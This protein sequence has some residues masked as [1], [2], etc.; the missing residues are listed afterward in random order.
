MAPSYR[1]VLKALLFASVIAVFVP[2]LRLGLCASDDYCYVR[3]CDFVTAGLTFHGLFRAF[4][5]LSQ[6]IWM[7]LTWL[8]YML[9]YSIGWGEWGM[10]L[11]NVLLHAVNALLLFA[12]LRRVACTLGKGLFAELVAFVAAV[13]WAVHPLRVESVV[14][15]AS[16]KDELSTLFLLLA[17]LVWIGGSETRRTLF[18]LSLV[19]VGAMAKPSVMVFP[20][21][22]L[23]LDWLVVGNVKRREAYVAAIALTAVIAWE[24]SVGQGVEAMEYGRQIPLGYRLLNSVAALT[25]YIGNFLWPDPLAVQCMIRYPDRPAF[26]AVGSF[27]LT[28]MLL[29]ILVLAVRRVLEMSRTRDWKM[30]CAG[31]QRMNT[32]LAGCLV[33]LGSFVPFLGIVGFGFH[34]F[35]DR[36]TLLPSMGLSILILSL[37]VRGGCRWLRGI[38]F[39]I[40]VATIPFLV[41]RTVDQVGYWKDD[42]TLFEHTIAVDGDRNVAAHRTCGIYY[43]EVKHDMEKVYVHLKKAY[44][45][46]PNDYIRDQMGSCLHFLVEAMYETGR[47][48]EAED[49]YFEMRKW[50]YRQ[51]RGLRHSMEF[52]SAEAMYLAHNG[53]TKEAMDILDELEHSD[54]DFYITRNLAYYLAK[55]DG[56][57][58]LAD[59]LR[60]E[61]RTTSGDA[62]C[63]NRWAI[64]K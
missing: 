64:V 4:A 31:T 9:D 35:A 17:V 27:V 1:R 59:R 34:A 54:P 36:F 18:A 63:R 58:N 19:A 50:D 53:R 11:M 24:A 55:A 15:I 5:D 48:K 51:F 13:I 39:F 3:S 2:A 16:R 25:I 32:V 60:R 8:S 56:K 22:A 29:G 57:A 6:S 33:L 37:S 14:W 40:L 41:L 45:C 61:C 42:G 43:W 20:V 21:F 44:E 49:M 46:A 12:L 7:P 28:C 23:A 52:K 38:T 30:L 26:S 10:H 47:P 62:Y